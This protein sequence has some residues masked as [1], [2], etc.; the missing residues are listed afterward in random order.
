LKVYLLH[1]IEQLRLVPLILPRPIEIWASHL[2]A[3]ATLVFEN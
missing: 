2:L 3:K 1:Y